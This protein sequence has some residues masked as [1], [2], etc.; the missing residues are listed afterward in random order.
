MKDS[1]PSARSPLCTRA[2]AYNTR[3]STTFMKNLSAGASSAASTK[4]AKYPATTLA[5]CAPYHDCADGAL[6]KLIQ[7]A[8]LGRDGCPTPRWMSSFASR[9]SRSRFSLTARHH[10]LPGRPSCSGLSTPRASCHRMNATTA[11]R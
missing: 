2:C 9:V 4:C 10:G 3:T 1:R 6:K 5:L 7:R 8:T 11:R